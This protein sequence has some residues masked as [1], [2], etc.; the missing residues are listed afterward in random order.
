MKNLLKK[1]HSSA[2]QNPRRIVYPEGTDPRTLAAIA[3]V[4]KKG[5]AHPIVLG[6][7]LRIKAL[8]KKLKLK[9]NWDKLKIINPASSALT[10][11][12]AQAMYQARKS[13]GMTEAAAL[14]ILKSK[15]GIY[16]YGTMMLYADDADGVVSGVVCT[17]SDTVKP[18]LQIIKTAEHF[19][20]VSGVFFMVL[21]NRLLIFADAAITIDPDAHDLVDI[22]EDTARTAIT[23]GINPRIAFL[24][25]STKGKSDHPHVSKVRQ[26]VEMLRY[27]Y[28]DIVADGEMQVD[29]ALVPS[30]AKIKC[31]GSKI[32]GDANIL[33]FPNL[34]SANIAYKLVERLAHAKAIGPL[35]QGLKKPVNDLSRG[36]S[37]QDIVDVT[38][39]TVCQSQGTCIECK[40]P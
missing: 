11:K 4:I 2:K 10:K 13:K 18:A 5:L 1:V 24:S 40:K 26:A 16:Y 32:Q 23:F 15:D 27:K 22:A 6:N 36:C 21:E 29:A 30:V 19:H 3:E 9:V 31:P 37:V 25:F 20:K 7:P 17:T 35:L 28:P 33:I 14:K 39:F 38:A 12:Y 8:A 34:S